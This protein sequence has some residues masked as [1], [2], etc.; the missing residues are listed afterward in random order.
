PRHAMQAIHES[1]QA[2]APEQPEVAQP[3]GDEARRAKYHDQDGDADE[4]LPAETSAVF[5]R[6]IHSRRRVHRRDRTHKRKARARRDRSR[7]SQRLTDWSGRG[8]P[9]RCRRGGTNNAGSTNAFLR[10]SVTV[11]RMRSS[12]NKA[13]IVNGSLTPSTSRLSSN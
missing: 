11:Y 6:S 1:A 8:R 4:K 9:N 12:M 7:S 3:P 2:P 10:A 13:M 5:R